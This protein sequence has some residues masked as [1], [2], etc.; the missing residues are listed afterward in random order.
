MIDLERLD[1]FL[2]SD[3]SP[4]DCMMLSDLDGFLHG[5]ACSPEFIPSH[6]WMP[7]ALG[8]APQDVPDWVIEAIALIYANICE[9]LMADLPEIE[10]IF[11]QAKEGHVIAMD[12][13]EGFMAAVNLKAKAWRAFM[14]SDEGMALMTPILVHMMDETGDSQVGLSQT[15]IDATLDWAAEAI[16]SAVPAIFRA[17]SPERRGPKS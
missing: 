14:Q 5:I 12:W 13:C 17:L 15:E 7:V 2:S 3:E 8:G 16:P 6:D 10:P 1:A 4:E 11:W 9:G